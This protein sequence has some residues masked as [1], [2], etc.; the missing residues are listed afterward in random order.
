ML[1]LIIR[2]TLFFILPHSHT[3]SS[4]PLVVKAGGIFIGGDFIQ[5]LNVTQNTVLASNIQV[6]QTFGTRFKGL[7]GKKYLKEGTGL[8]IKPCCQIH[9][10]GMKFNFDAVFLDSNLV[11]CHI[12]PNMRPGEISRFVRNAKCVVELPAGTISDSRTQI[13][14]H[15]NLTKEGNH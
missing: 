15:I 4:L 10:V 3:L 1:A 5:V 8:F 7:L 2:H 14:D 11:V 9:S 13:G 12:H 6:A